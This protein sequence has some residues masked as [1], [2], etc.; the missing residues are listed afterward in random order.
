MDGREVEA[1]CLEKGCVEC[2][3]DTEMPLSRSDRRRLS[4][5]GHDVE[6]FAVRGEDGFWLLANVAGRC[7]FLDRE[8][9]RCR[10]YPDRP[11]GCRLYPL[12]LDEGLSEFALDDLCPHRD[13][14]E[15]GEEDRQALLELLDRLARER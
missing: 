14:V 3:I 6:R 1:P 5:L 13:A 4:R 15:P 2:C 12:V 10:V 9:G 7:Y 11:E 8:N